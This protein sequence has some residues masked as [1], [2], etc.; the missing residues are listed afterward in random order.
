VRAELEN[1]LTEL[2]ECERVRRG[3]EKE[4]IRPSR[5]S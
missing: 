1:K 4:R 2:V 5:W 3:K